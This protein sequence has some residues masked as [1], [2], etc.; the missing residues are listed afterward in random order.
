MLATTQPYWLRTWETNLNFVCVR[1][2][3]CVHSMFERVRQESG[4]HSLFTS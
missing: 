4:S 1:M 2:C 3:V